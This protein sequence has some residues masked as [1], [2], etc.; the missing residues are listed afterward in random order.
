MKPGGRGRI[1]LYS[2]VTSALYR[3]GQPHIPATL[4]LENELLV[5]IQKEASWVPGIVWMQISCPC[6]AQGHI[7]SVIH[8][9]A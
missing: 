2:S 7:S 6:Q 4:P 5:A 8:P 1:Q 9:V 3:S